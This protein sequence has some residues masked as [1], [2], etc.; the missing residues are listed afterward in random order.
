M[1]FK[2]VFLTCVVAFGCTNWMF[3]MQI[4]QQ[5][6]ERPAKLPC[7]HMPDEVRPN[8]AVTY[9]EFRASPFSA[10]TKFA[11]QQAASATDYQTTRKF[12]AGCVTHMQIFLSIVK[13]ATDD[14]VIW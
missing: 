11:L 8:A 2:L 10:L 13:D 14:R 1:N 9:D 12:L 7:F 4:N 3:G 5:V 6:D